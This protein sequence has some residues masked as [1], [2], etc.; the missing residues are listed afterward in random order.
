MGVFVYLSEMV[1][2]IVL[3]KNNQKVGIL[4]DFSMK[5]NDEVYPRTIGLV[6]KK[7]LLRGK[8]GH[9]ETENIDSIDDV[10]KLG[11]DGAELK[12]Q[13]T[14]QKYDFTLSKDILDQQVVDT[15]NQKVVRVNDVH[16]LK[17]E[18]QLYL[19][20]VDVGFRGIIR[21][22][23]W[24][25]AVDALVRFVSPTSPF[26][27]HQE[28]IPWKNTQVLSLGRVK[29]VLRL[30]VARRKLSN[31]PPTELAEI[32]EDLDIFEKFALFKS[33]DVQMQRKVFTDISI[34]EK[35]ELV[36]QMSDSE[37]ADLLENIPADEATDLLM[38]LPKEKTLQLM[39]LMENDTSK[40]LRKLLGFARDTAGGL[41][42]TEYLCLKK[43]AL[44]SNALEKIKEN[45][46]FPGNIFH[47]Y[48]VDDHHRLVGS[49]SLRNIINADLDT[50][51]VDTCYPKKVFVHTD[52]GMEEVALLMEKYKFSSIPVLNEEEILQG[53]ITSDDV[54]EELISLAW[55]KYKDQL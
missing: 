8:Y 3:D 46:Q 48:V 16:L 22:L 14:P 4:Y 28:F 34:A 39:R 44:V 31:I 25:K 13:R 11:I 2:K 54:M 49:T 37:V 51:I 53:V 55:G 9:V 21:R 36:D 41:M 12:F 32:M 33:L 26:L 40:K 43:D 19:A 6:V 52:D 45:A 23:G 10:L 35:E 5:I 47:I 18:N 27:S 29:N 24:T 30:D 42:T 20:H 50:P 1:G 17:V 38:A 15:D 7:G